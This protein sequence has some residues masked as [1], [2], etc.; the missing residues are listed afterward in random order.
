MRL[1]ALCL[2]LAFAASATPLAAAQAEAGQ[3]DPRLAE[4]YAADQADRRPGDDPDWSA[5]GRRDADRRA[6]V[7]Q[8][9]DAGAVRT[10]ADHYH[11]AMVFQH[12]SDSTAYRKAWDLA[13]EAERLGSARARWLAAAAEDRYRLSVGERQRYGTQFLIEDGTWYL[14]PFDSTAVTDEERLRVGSRTL[15]EIRAYLAGKNGTPTG[16]LAA[17]PDP[18]EEAAPTVELWD[19]IAGLAAKI[20]YPEAAMA[21]GVEGG[22]RVELVVLPDGSVGDAFVVDG[23]G[24]GLDEEALRVVR[25]AEFVN[26][27][28]E[29]WTIR[30]VVPFELPGSGDE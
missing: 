6:E 29:P 9:L 10:A 13:R 23:L 26:H 28:G 19:G 12:G 30:L 2:L 15:D 21:A 7:D 1:P 4:L 17:Q 16:S 24:H 18:H 20:E 22:V 14:S 11:A 8:L 27:V 25:Q 3:D 5:I